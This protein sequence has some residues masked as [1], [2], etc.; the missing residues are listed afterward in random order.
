MLRLWRRL[1]SPTRK[2]A[3]H[4]EDA[5]V[6]GADVPSYWPRSRKRQELWGRPEQ[7]E[8]PGTRTVPRTFETPGFLDLVCR[9]ATVSRGGARFGA[10]PSSC[11]RSSMVRRGRLRGCTGALAVGGRV[12]SPEPGLLPVD[13]AGGLATAVRL[14][15]AAHPR[16]VHRVAHPP[17]AG[18]GH[19]VAQLV[20]HLVH[21]E[22]L[23]AVL[24]H[25][26]HERQRVELA[27]VVQRRQDLLLAADLDQLADAQVEP[28]PGGRRPDLHSRTSHRSHPSNAADR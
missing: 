2:R 13:E 1:N 17:H 14:P 4:R 12:D 22:L 18:P 3:E 26:G 25:L 8:S 24:Q 19:R 27:V 11:R 16:Q 28:P 7:L 5:H 21:G 15:V 9:S 10:P 23:A 6:A 20:G